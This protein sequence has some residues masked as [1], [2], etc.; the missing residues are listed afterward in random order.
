MLQW[1]EQ[2]TKHWCF[3]LWC[4]GC[5]LIILIAN[6]CQ[7]LGVRNKV[8]MDHDHEEDSS[9]SKGSFGKSLPF[10]QWRIYWRGNS[11]LDSRY[12]PLFF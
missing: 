12:F 7:P 1:W 3:R 5:S 2:E 11:L 8:K 4:A 9:N 10:V 6:I